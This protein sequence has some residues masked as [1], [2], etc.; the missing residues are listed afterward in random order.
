MAF[1][2]SG[3]PDRLP[4]WTIWNALGRVGLH[5]KALA[6]PRG[7][8]RQLWLGR[9]WRTSGQSEAFPANMEGMLSQILGWLACHW[10]FGT[11]GFLPNGLH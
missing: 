1:R 9:G 6:K 4:I 7:F 2:R 10:D 5:G 3:I 11:K 8:G